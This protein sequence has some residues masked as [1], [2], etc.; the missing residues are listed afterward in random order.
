MD[1]RGLVAGSKLYLPV[2]VPG[3]L[4]SIGDLHFAQGDG[5]TCGTGIEMS[6]A[7]TVRFRVHKSP[8]WTPTFPAYETPAA[9]PRASFA[10]TGVPVTEDGRNESMDL[11]LAT[12][13][14][15]VEMIDHVEKERGLSREAGY[16]LISIAA[17]LR[18]SEVVDVPNPMVSVV[19][20]LDIFEEPPPES[21]VLRTRRQE[22][23][24]SIATERRKETALLG[25]LETAR[26]DA[27]AWQA[28]ETVTSK[29]DEPT[30]ATL[31][32]IGF[33]ASEPS[34]EAGQRLREHVADLE[35]QLGEARERRAALERY[36]HALDESLISPARGERSR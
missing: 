20:P 12:R 15:L 27:T 6:G 3:A 33:V 18:L 13:R 17:D 14:A 10:T 35:R 2:H 5:E 25:R 22:A 16:V 11:D 28:D 8:T 26:R 23:T 1:V 36:V 21:I 30:L 19:M 32:E 7:A 24:G 29:L 34:A 4:F 31:R 9:A